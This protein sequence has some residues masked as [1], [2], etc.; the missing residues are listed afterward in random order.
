MF[1]YLMQGATLALAAT[2]M[3]GPF[4]A[5][6]ISYALRNGWK[7]T[8]PAAFAP[9]VTDGPVIVLVIFVL[10]K[11][12][13]WLL[14]ILHVAGGLVILFFAWKVFAS[15]KERGAHIK[16]MS[17][18][19]RKTLVGAIAM[20][21]LN[22]SPYI[23]WSVVAGPILLEAWR[24]A[25][26]LGVSFVSGFYGTFVLSLALFIIMFGTVGR[27]RPRLNHLLSIISALALVVFGFYEL[28]TGMTKVIMFSSL[29]GD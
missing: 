25:K 3:P 14:N 11:T 19:A 6:L 22:P 27:M 13:Q 15:L 7:R 2:L 1:F 8:L 20:N 4:Q 18:A 26:T 29:T 9:L 21:I 10:A 5:L 12:P 24:Q 16:P 23:F 17:K 28:G